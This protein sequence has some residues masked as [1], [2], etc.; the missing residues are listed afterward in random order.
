MAYYEALK[1]SRKLPKNIIAE[2][3]VFNEITKSKITEAM[4]TLEKLILT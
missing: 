1:K 2:R 4:Q 3:V